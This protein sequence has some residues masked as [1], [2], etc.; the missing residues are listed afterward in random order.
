M[1]GRWLHGC[2]FPSAEGSDLGFVNQSCCYDYL[3]VQFHERKC[4]WQNLDCGE[5][6]IC[7]YKVSFPLNSLQKFFETKGNSSFSADVEKLSQNNSR[8]QDQ[9]FTFLRKIEN[10]RRLRSET[11]VIREIPSERMSICYIHG[12]ALVCFTLRKKRSFCRGNVL[13]VNSDPLPNTP[14]RTGVLFGQIGAMEL[15]KSRRS[16]ANSFPIRTNRSQIAAL[17]VSSIS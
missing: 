11:S 6:E 12:S 8:D 15:Q 13:L 1:H 4:L 3:V 5:I 7:H 2:V 16:S 17:D 14:K 9:A 10:P